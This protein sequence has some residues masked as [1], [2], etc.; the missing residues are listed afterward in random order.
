MGSDRPSIIVPEVIFCCGCL[1]TG[2]FVAFNAF[3]FGLTGYPGGCGKRKA[4]FRCLM[5][6]SMLGCWHNV[7]NR[8]S[9]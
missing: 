3:A 8:E 2:S 4:K 5:G 6:V 1:A 9:D 7:L